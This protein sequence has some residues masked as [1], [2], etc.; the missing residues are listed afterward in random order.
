MGG[1][2]EVFDAS[3]VVGRV[4]GPHELLGGVGLR[5][6]VVV[7]ST[8]RSVA[9]TAT[10]GAVGVFSALSEF[11]SVFAHRLGEWCLRSGM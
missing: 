11:V 8:A 6:S 2:D 3:V 7:G 9:V 4:A 1:F 5:L 10:A